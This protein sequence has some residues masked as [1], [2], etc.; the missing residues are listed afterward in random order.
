VKIHNYIRLYMVFCCSVATDKFA[1]F[2]RKHY[3]L[4]TLIQ[5]SR[6]LHGAFSKLGGL[7]PGLW[8]PPPF[9]RE[10]PKIHRV[11]KNKQN[12]FCYNYVKL[13]PNL[14]IFGTKMANSLKLYY[15]MYSFSTSN[16]SRQCTIMLNAHAPNCH[17]TL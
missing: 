7:N 4:V 3:G 14:I 2:L 8:K 15:E 6:L 10:I 13:P 9:G 17:I 5:D 11:S 12:Y 16:N 1:E